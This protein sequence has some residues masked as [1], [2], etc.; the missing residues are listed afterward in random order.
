MKKT[1][2]LLGILTLV[3]MAFLPCLDNGFTNWDDPDLITENP[4]IRHLTL[5]GIREIFTTPVFNTYSPLVFLSYAVEYHF[6]G[7]APFLYHL[8]NLILHVLACGLVFWWAWL[9]SRRWAVAALTTLVFGLH[10]LRVE[11]VAWITERKDL[12]CSVFFLSA[13]VAYVYYRI[14]HRPV[15][16][17]LSFLGILLSFLAKPQAI[18]FPF[19]LLLIDAIP[20]RK[21]DRVV[22]WEKVPFAVLSAIFFLMRMSQA[23]ASG[24]LAS[25]SV[26]QTGA[27][28]LTAFYSL[29]FYLSKIVA[30]IGLA[31]LYPRP[32]DLAGAGLWF[33][34]LSPLIVAGLAA[35]VVVSL[36]YTRQVLFASLF[37]LITIAFPLLSGLVSR[38]VVH[39]HYTYLP[40]IGLSLLVSEGVVW[41]YDR[42]GPSWWWRRPALLVGVVV[43]VVAMGL[44]TWQRCGVWRDSLSLWTDAARVYPRLFP[45][46]NNLGTALAAQGR[47][48]EAIGHFQ[49]ALRIDPLSD[50]AHTSLGSALAGKG[51][52]AE[53]IGHFREALRLNP[54]NA[55]VHNNLGLALARLDHM[56]EAMG[57]FQEALRLQPNMA[58]AHNTMG[59]ILARQRRFSEAIGHFEEALRI[60]PDF[61]G[62]ARNLETARRAM[63]RAAA[64][65]PP[66]APPVDAGGS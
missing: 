23:S 21:L 35:G 10:P 24:E 2:I 14:R 25:E 45:V 63:Q 58:A 4:I 53:A 7:L 28:L 54:G 33:Y 60:R 65:S 39:D 1:V 51:R 11:S 48:D 64:S 27:H 62:A 22:L 20:F 30:P 40:S 8:N 16:Y 13:L 59:V 3:V 42:P 6:V 56:D 18:L 44:Q 46:Q 15:Y 55:T 61:K 57:H 32:S 43:I 9:L 17:G 37:F 34:R 52:T 47:L 50:E 26:G 49:E 66:A 5:D 36:R 19:L 12:L 41:F 38:S 31:C 29:A